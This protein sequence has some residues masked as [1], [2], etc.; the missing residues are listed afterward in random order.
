MKGIFLRSPEGEFNRFAKSLAGS[1][2]HG[3]GGVL[4]TGFHHYLA[5]PSP[6]ANLGIEPWNN[7][8]SHASL[9]IYIYPYYHSLTDGT[10]IGSCGGFKKVR[11]KHTGLRG[12]TWAADWTRR[13]QLFAVDD[14]NRTPPCI[15]RALHLGKRKREANGFCAHPGGSDEEQLLGKPDATRAQ[16]T[17]RES[18]AAESDAAARLQEE[19]DCTG[20]DIT[21]LHLGDGTVEFQKM[22]PAGKTAWRARIHNTLAAQQCPS[23]LFKT[24]YAEKYADL[25]GDVYKWW[26]DSGGDLIFTVGVGSSHCHTE[27]VQ[28]GGETTWKG[29]LYHPFSA[30]SCTRIEAN[31]EETLCSKLEEFWVRRHPG[32]SPGVSFCGYQ[33][34]ENLFVDSRKTRATEETLKFSSAPA[35]SP[36][37][38]LTAPAPPRAASSQ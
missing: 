28:Q 19:G 23:R 7:R 32:I 21:V 5:P 18:D 15:Q 33:I 10:A 22:K 24:M 13:L 38:S 29:T 9:I 31:D 6:F 30:D 25:A 16:E 37:A 3:G 11:G 1:F 4:L 8:T 26:S 34:T 27:K 35:P 12:Q 14:A 36:Q 20:S 2:C 17:A